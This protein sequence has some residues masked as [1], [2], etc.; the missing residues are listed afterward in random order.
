VEAPKQAERLLPDQNLL[1]E[2]FEINKR[3]EDDD[4]DSEVAE[5]AR[6]KS[7]SHTRK[8]EKKQR[9][10]EAAKAAAAAGASLSITVPDSATA[11]AVEH[12]SAKSV[13]LKKVEKKSRKSSKDFHAYV[14]G[15]ERS[16]GD[17]N[18]NFDEDDTFDLFQDGGGP[19]HKK[20]SNKHSIKKKSSKT[21]HAILGD[22][23]N[24]EEDDDGFTQKPIRGSSSGKVV[25]KSQ[26]SKKAPSESSQQKALP[27]LV[28]FDD[29]SVPIIP[30]TAIKTKVKSKSSS[31]D[32]RNRQE[33]KIR[34]VSR[35]RSP[36]SL[37]TSSSKS[38]DKTNKPTKATANETD[39]LFGMDDFSF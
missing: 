35:S 24:E 38:K 25:A 10:K 13:A 12:T 39:W 36:P 17:G 15:D 30:S 26:M 6:A 21:P 16:D 2:Q 37:S 9:K 34:G 31:K 32:E 7:S 11:I 8:L 14:K 33:E 3:H 5:R 18:F 1:E 23:L 27:V 20:S 29:E 19:I 22:S 4:A 28:P